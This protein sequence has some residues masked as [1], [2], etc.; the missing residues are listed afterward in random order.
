[1]ARREQ[2]NTVLPIPNGWFAVEWS[3]DLIDGQVKSIHYF[4]EDLVI[5]R[6][7][8]GEAHGPD[9]YCPPPGAPLGA[10]V[11]A[12]RGLLIAISIVA[13][14]AMAALSAAFLLRGL[15]REHEGV[16]EQALTD[17]LTGLANHRRFRETIAQEVERRPLVGEHDRMAED[18]A[19][20]AR[21]AEGHAARAAR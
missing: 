14:I 9:P 21:R 19:G 5:F 16:V 11:L 13:F 2:E 18:E 20:H 6:G 4:G 8:S 17:A 10:S 12:G 7:R 3:K 15:G 1:V